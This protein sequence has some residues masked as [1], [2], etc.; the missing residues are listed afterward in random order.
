MPK[1]SAS[2]PKGWGERWAA[3]ARSVEAGRYDEFRMPEG[4]PR[5]IWRDWIEHLGQPPEAL[6]QAQEQV[7]RQIREDGI[8]YNVYNAAG[9]STGPWS[10]EPLPFL[11]SAPE[12]S[13]LERGIAQRADLLN[14]VLVD[15]YGPQTL[16]RE[17]M[18]PSALVLGHP[19]YLRGLQGTQPLGDVYLHVVAFD[20][21][22]GPDGNWWVVGQ[23][24]QAPSGLG[25]VMQNRLI[26]SRLFPEAYRAMNVQHLASTYR[27]LLDTI[28]TLADQCAG[29]DMPS[30]ALLTPGP[31]NE[32]Y[33]EQSYLARYLGLPLVEGSDLI[34]RGDR[35]FM[36]TVQGLKP[37]HGLLRRL[38]DDF[39]DPLE[40]RTDST[41]GIAGLTQVVRAG[42]VVLANALGS[43]FL[44]S[45]ALHGFLP[46]L[47]KHLLGEDLILPSLPTWWCGEASA[48]A[49]VRPQ[50]AEQ[51]IRPTYPWQETPGG[52]SAHRRRQQ[53]TVL[54]A[55]LTPQEVKAW[56]Q[57]VA[58]SPAAHTVQNFIP[59]AQT[60]VWSDE[61][62]S[63]RS[64]SVRVYA[65]SDGQGGWR[66]LPGG[67][68]RIATRDD[69]PVSL[70][71]GGSSLDTWVL[72]DDTVD[73]FSMLPN[74]IKLE[75]LAQRQR[76]VASRTAENLFWMGRYTERCEQQLRLTERLLSVRA[77]DDEPDQAL[78]KALSELGVE[79]GMVPADTPPLD[80][81]ERVFE[82]VAL[83]ALSDLNAKQGAYSLAFNLGALSRTAQALRERLSPAHARLLRA[84]SNDFQLALRQDDPLEPG[85]LG[86][87][88][89]KVQD[90]LAHLSVQLGAVTG[91]QSDHM[92]RDPGWRLLTVGRLIERLTGH[93]SILKAFWRHQALGHAQGFDQILE[94]FDSTITFRARFQRRL[95][96]PALVALLVMDE[97][98][99]RALACVLRRLRSEVGKLPAREGASPDLLALLPSD[100]VGMELA[101]LCDPETGHAK[102][103]A[104]LDHLLTA[105]WQL[106]DEIG[107]LYFAHS[108][109]KDAMVSA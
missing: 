35:L 15:T 84:A 92:T 3:S 38:D 53:E 97:N 16:L 36:K 96:V 25:Y 85:A 51:V 12:W 74:A 9:G 54:G 42:N 104:L 82:R 17:A 68:T 105:G 40:L 70:Q 4:G 75:E 87:H 57:T 71:L 107:R 79:F 65:L 55:T 1:R 21:A 89:V 31:Y 6:R 30:L 64:A 44:E 66:V 32:T 13:G 8:S 77:E 19:G 103:E 100:G 45:P 41:L 101:A 46:A 76:P 95:E 22:R 61:G 23:R 14:R 43:G 91:A 28:S 93:A 34:V 10:L 73:A 39:C 2:Q 102:V 69:G 98:N 62:L 20:L 26:V 67:M 11:I 47:S 59:F 108:E 48:W 78:L 63:L 88:I 49:D 60:P 5:P 52:M 94:L 109:A 72:T 90:A 86:A 50:L 99:Q 106:S 24:T 83:D 58:L 56:E 18:L 80:R 27:Q 33:F 37:I 7:A 81:S 29:G